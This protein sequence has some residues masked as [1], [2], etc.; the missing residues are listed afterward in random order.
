M[1]TEVTDTATDARR[2]AVTQ[3][4][5]SKHCIFRCNQSWY[6]IPAMEIIEI[7]LMPNLTRLPDSPKI[8]LGVC[9]CRHEFTP[10]ISLEQITS[11]ADAKRSGPPKHIMILDGTQRWAIALDEIVSLEPLETVISQET[12]GSDGAIHPITGTAMHAEK[13]IK[14]LDPQRLRQLATSAFDAAWIR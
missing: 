9:H 14:V 12:R 13:I 7:T 10:V 6:S 8:L 3:T 11:H 5:Q 4:S 1:L 2:S